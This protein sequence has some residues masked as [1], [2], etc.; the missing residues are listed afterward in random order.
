MGYTGSIGY[1]GS[2]GATGLQGEIGATGTAG[3]SGVRG[4]TGSV[5]ATGATGPAGQGVSI[6]GYVSDITYL[7]G[8]NDT[9]LGNFGDAFLLGN[10]H[11]AVWNGEQFQDVGVIQGPSGATGA[12]GATGPIGYTGS[13]ALVVLSNTLFVDVAG[14]DVTANGTAHL[15]YRTIQA[16]HNYAATISDST[17][18]IIQV[19]PGTYTENVTITRPNVYIVGTTKGTF[20]TAQINGTVTVNLPSSSNNRVGFEKVY[21]SKTLILAGSNP[22]EL[23]GQDIYIADSTSSGHAINVTNTS[24]NGIQINFDTCQIENTVSTE[25]VIKLNNT[26]AIFDSV[27][28]L[29]NLNLA[30]DI[31]NSNLFLLNSRI[32]GNGERLIDA[33]NYSRGGAAISCSNTRMTNDNVN[34]TGINLNGSVTTA[35]CVQCHFDIGSS[36]GTGFAVSGASGTTLVHGNN[37]FYPGGNN[38]LSTNVT[39]QPYTTSFAT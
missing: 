30:I 19:M 22:Y 33:Y 7:N 38:K 16:A 37:L 13:T 20:K 35:I 18:I 10:G 14:N 28:V 23:Y 8:P 27:V 32:F 9:I 12:T 11:L 3:A 6:L 26:F 24:T 5:G 15:P 17:P 36:S 39:S 25:P 34:G 29:S 4:Y 21:I 1:T 2:R 31:T